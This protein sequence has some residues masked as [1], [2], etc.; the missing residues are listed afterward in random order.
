MRGKTELHGGAGCVMEGKIE[1]EEEND[2]AAS[3]FSE[4]TKAWPL[5]DHSEGE[6]SGEFPNVITTFDVPLRAPK[7][8]A[9]EVPEGSLEFYVI[10]ANG[11][12][13]LPAL[14]LKNDNGEYDRVEIYLS[15]KDAEPWSALKDGEYLPTQVIE[16]EK[17]GQK[18]KGTRSVSIMKIDNN[19]PSVQISLGQ[20][21]DIT[22]NVKELTWHPKSLYQ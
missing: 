2:G 10:I 9:H 11:L 20:C 1:E 3:F 15:K 22:T 6:E 8:W 19:L 5:L 13:Q 18:V 7:N 17:E 16:M 14:L 21:L 12:K 4:D